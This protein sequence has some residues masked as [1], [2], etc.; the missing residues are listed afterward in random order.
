MQDVSDPIIAEGIEKRLSHRSRLSKIDPE[1][2][3]FLFQ[4]GRVL[5]AAEFAV[6]YLL[7]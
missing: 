3:T 4:E 1:I 5:K 6:G 2:R 7:Q